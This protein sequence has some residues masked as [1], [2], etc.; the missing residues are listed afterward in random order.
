MF[1]NCLIV[2]G[3]IICCKGADASRNINTCTTSHQAVKHVK[4]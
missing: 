4:Y 1:R 3:H 2:L